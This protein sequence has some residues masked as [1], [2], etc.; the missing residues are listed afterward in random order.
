MQVDPEERRER[1]RAGRLRGSIAGCSAM[2]R[3][4]WWPC[5]RLLKLSSAFK[6]VPISPDEPA[7]ISPCAQLLSGSSTQEVCLCADTQMDTREQQLK[8]LN[9]QLPCRWKS[10]SHVPLVAI[11][12]KLDLRPYH[13]MWIMCGSPWKLKFHSRVNNNNTS[14]W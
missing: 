4:V 13:K 7:S 8:L 11:I 1:R 3:K 14:H 10:E 2:L 6:A 12:L 5:Q 9:N